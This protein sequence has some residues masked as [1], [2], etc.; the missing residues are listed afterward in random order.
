MKVRN[1]L[2]NFEFLYVSL[3][4]IPIIFV[5]KKKLITCNFC[6]SVLEI[7]HEASKTTGGEIKVIS[8]GFPNLLKL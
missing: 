8:A 1:H 5:L 3:K 2:E 6:T 4:K 7:K